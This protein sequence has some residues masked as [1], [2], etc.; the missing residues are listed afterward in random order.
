[1]FWM[2]RSFVNLS[3]LRI[4]ISRTERTATR[5]GF[6]V[7]A[8]CQTGQDIA[9]GRR[10]LKR[11]WPVMVQPLWKA[12]PGLQATFSRPPYENRHHH[13]PTFGCTAASGGMGA[14]RPFSPIAAQQLAY[15]A[16]YAPTDFA[17]CLQ[18]T[19]RRNIMSE[20]RAPTTHFPQLYL[21][22]PLSTAH[23]VPAA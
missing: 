13:N 3:K 2:K 17:F 11:Y 15:F 19:K 1:M 5:H 18:S 22:T 20:N 23:N 16:Q 4:K 10:W 9:L 12:H 7:R 6:S 21:L 8:N 14:V